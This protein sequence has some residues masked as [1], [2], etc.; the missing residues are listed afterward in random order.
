MFAMKIDSAFAAMAAPT[1]FGLVAKPTTPF[2]VPSMV[3]KGTAPAA[4]SVRPTEAPGLI[5]AVEAAQE[6]QSRR[7]HRQSYAERLL[8]RLAQLVTG[9]AIGTL[10]SATLEGLAGSL[11]P[12]EG[13]SDD[14]V[15]ESLVEAIELRA[16]VE[17]AKIEARTAR[18]REV[19]EG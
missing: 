10:D 6:R 17:M 14:P 7:K 4:A 16:A 12:M 13:P 1:R 15:L 11:R 8:D 18:F 5:A 19:G 9:L 3:E 2:R